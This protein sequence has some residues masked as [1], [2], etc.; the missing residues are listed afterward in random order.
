MRAPF[1]EDSYL[2]V[3][4]EAPLI[5]ETA[6]EGIDWATQIEVRDSRRN[7]G[8][9]L[10]HESEYDAA[11][12]KRAGAMIHDL[13]VMRGDQRAR[14]SSMGYRETATAVSILFNLEE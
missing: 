1:R 9:D 8:I 2:R 6:F 11:R 10:T 4:R 12:V 13:L 3:D 14:I 5:Q 7:Q